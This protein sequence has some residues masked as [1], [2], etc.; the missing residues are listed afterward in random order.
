M[1]KVGFES[2]GI[3]KTNKA[4]KSTDKVAQSTAKSVN[5]VNKQFQAQQSIV[6]QLSGGV[7]LLGFSFN[8]VFDTLTALD[9][10]M[11]GAGR[12]LTEFQGGF[13]AVSENG[14]SMLQALGGGFD[15]LVAGFKSGAFTIRGVL[16]TSLAPIAL[17]VAGIYTL[18]KVWDNN[19]GGIQTKFSKVVGQM[20]T[21]FGKF[22]VSFI[23]VL[24][25][26]EPFFSLLFD[27]IFAYIKG[28]GKLF[29]GIFSGI[30]AILSPIIDVF[31]EL[32]E[33]LGDAFG[34]SAKS[35]GGFVSIMSALGT[36]LKY[37]G[38]TI[39]F[40]LKIALIPMTKG[41]ESLAKIIGWLKTGWNKL[42]GAFKQTS[43]FK[44]LMNLFER[45]RDVIKNVINWVDKIPGVD[46]PDEI[47]TAVNGN[48]AG[49]NQNI[50][51]NNQQINVNTSRE[52]SSGAAPGFASM[53]AAQLDN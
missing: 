9:G 26:L 29:S 5:G 6:S 41:I 11:R 50:K 21:A 51:N 13:N 18:K 36:V 24:K 10:R 20:K 16:L 28:F 27:T 3:G 30:G 39:G 42:I 1:Y 19:I 48:G 47:K 2:V 32:G 49:G 4:I 31:A 34:S 38:K 25:K 44:G 17:V 22:E 53:L 33:V 43:V 40:V 23:K 12:A 52:I 45:I 8:T 46:I 37:V 14:G 15:N 7:N 35:G